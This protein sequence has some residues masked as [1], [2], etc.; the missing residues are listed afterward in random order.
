[1]RAA[2]L[3]LTLSGCAMAPASGDM[4]SRAA[5]GELI[6]EALACDA[7]EDAGCTE[8]P[9]RI[10]V[11]ALRCR[12]AATPEHPR[13]VHCRFSGTQVRRLQTREFG[14]ECFWLNREPGGP[15]RIDIWPDADVCDS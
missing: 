14:P 9:R 3:F 12:P 15:W 13:R 4:P 8:Q 5:V 2:I 11:H 10:I 1:M 6:R 7:S